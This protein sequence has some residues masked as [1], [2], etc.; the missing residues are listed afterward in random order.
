MEGERASPIEE[1]EEQG[2]E[3]PMKEGAEEILEL[4]AEEWRTNRLR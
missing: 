3:D 4:A 1:P 2:E